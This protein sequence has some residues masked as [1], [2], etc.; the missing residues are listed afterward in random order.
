MV[1]DY[2]RKTMR[3]VPAKECFQACRGAAGGDTGVLRRG[4]GRD[5]VE[6]AA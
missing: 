6:R 4:M 2:E 5:E 3:P 1:I